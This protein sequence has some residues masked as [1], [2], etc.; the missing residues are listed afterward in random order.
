MFGRAAGVGVGTG[1]GAAG[2]PPPQPARA[3]TPTASV[4]PHAVRHSD[5]H[6]EA[7]GVYAAGAGPVNAAPAV[8]PSLSTMHAL[9]MRCL[10]L[11][12]LGLALAAVGLRRRR[13]LS[14]V[15]GAGAGGDPRGLH[16]RRPRAAQRRAHPGGRPRLGRPRQLRQHADPDAEHRPV[17]GRGRALH[18]LLRRRPDLRALAGRADDRSLAPAGRHPVEPAEPAQPRRGRHRRAAARSGLRHRHA[19]QVAPRLVGRPDADP[20]R[21][22]LLLR[23]RD[24]RGREQLRPRRPADEGHR[25]PR[26]VRVPLHA[27]RAQVHRRHRPQPAL[28]RLHRPPR[29][30][31]AQHAGLP[32]RGHVG[33]RERT[34]TPSR[35][36]TSRWASSSRG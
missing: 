21:L 32:V 8:V 30:A 12:S 23:H 35:R 10:T 20:L 18:E 6:E 4:P 25:Q 17:G 19:R 29:P 11:L 3:N 16:S 13:L 15:S 9:P 14:L 34:A 1:A 5:R 22:R 31:P 2:E 26:P 36:S 27:G 7:R 33:G 24:R 28:L